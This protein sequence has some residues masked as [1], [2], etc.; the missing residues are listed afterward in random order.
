V[1]TFG[2]PVAGEKT[3]SRGNFLRM[4]GV[5]LAGLGVLGVAGP[6][7]GET[8][9]E[10]VSA[11]NL[12][13]RP[14]NTA[15]TN[16]VNLVRA[17]AYSKRHVVFP[18]GDYRIDNSGTPPIIRNF[19]GTVDFE[20][21]A[22]FIFTNNRTKGLVYQGG[23]WAR[24]Y[25]LNTTFSTLPPVRVTAQ[26][27]LHFV[28]TTDTLIQ[29]AVVNGSA[30]AGILFG[31]SVRPTVRNATISNTR[32]DGLHFSACGGVRVSSLR[33][34]NTGDD[35]LAFLDYGGST[36]HGGYAVDIEVR[37]SKARG[38]AVVGQRDVEICDFLVHGTREAGL[39]VAR[40][41]SYGTATPANVSYHDGKVVRAGTVLKDGSPG[42]NRHS[43]FYN[44]ATDRITFS[45]I[46]S[47][48][49]NALH[50]DT[51]GQP[52]RATLTDIIKSSTC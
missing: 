26:E 41:L 37:N 42:A 45:R 38:I 48:C 13:I 9:G 40:E 28:K 23:T 36:L 35:G 1:E 46:V 50:V 52:S 12:G 21:S 25:N 49:P 31:R 22:R 29:N 6:S 30:A 18:A 14:A 33:T 47:H 15:T 2:V 39:Y 19:G 17:L 8:T 32:A 20:P 7:L 27:C 51:G 44:G 5:G 34:N 16:R 10:I 11:L 4:G 24:F 3:I 43:I